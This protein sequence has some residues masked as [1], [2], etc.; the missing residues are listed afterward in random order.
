[1]IMKK[2]KE[3][4]IVIITLLVLSYVLFSLYKDTDKLARLGLIN[5]KTQTEVQTEGPTTDDTEE[6][7]CLT[8]PF[9]I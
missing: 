2:W 3:T 9:F 5:Y 6:S 8:L 7:A 1:M 4:V